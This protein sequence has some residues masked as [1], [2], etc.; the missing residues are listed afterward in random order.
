MDKKTEKVIHDHWRDLP[1]PV[2]CFPPPPASSIDGGLLTAGSE[3]PG[4]RSK[5]G[6][7]EWKSDLGKANAS[8]FA[9]VN[10]HGGRLIRARA[11][12]IARS[13]FN[14]R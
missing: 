7:A 5:E 9:R 13:D 14:F 3:G 1:F 12:C 4:I 8:R 10:G 11:Y 2:C 6:G